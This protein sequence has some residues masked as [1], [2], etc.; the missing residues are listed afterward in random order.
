MA[1]AGGFGD[2]KDTAVGLGAGLEECK[3]E[4]DEVP[5]KDSMVGDRMGKF[6][7]IDDTRLCEGS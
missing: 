7:V 2:G 6:W 4:G 5:C 1:A 3:F